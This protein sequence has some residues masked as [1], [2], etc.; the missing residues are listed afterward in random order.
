[1]IEARGK[2]KEPGVGAQVTSIKVLLSFRLG[3][4]L[5]WHASFSSDRG[6]HPTFRCIL[7]FAWAHAAPCQRRICGLANQD[8]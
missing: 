6:H 7:I 5:T 2:K 3:N 4:R 8:G 1:V